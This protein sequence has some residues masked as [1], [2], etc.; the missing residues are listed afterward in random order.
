M[1]SVCMTGTPDVTGGSSWLDVTAQEGSLEPPIAQ[2]N[3]LK[4]LLNTL[5]SHEDR[6]AAITAAFKAVVSLHKGE[7]GASI[8]VGGSCTVSTNNRLDE[9]YFIKTA[10]LVKAPWLLWLQEDP[11][12]EEEMGE[13]LLHLDR[14]TSNVSQP[15]RRAASEGYDD[16][17]A[18]E[19]QGTTGSLTAEGV[20]STAR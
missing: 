9:A 11:G 17:P 13:A 15:L 3:I 12:K 4:Q 2:E 8:H 10:G 1:C 16:L 18:N 7:V 19:P 6:D 5:Y 20:K 14:G